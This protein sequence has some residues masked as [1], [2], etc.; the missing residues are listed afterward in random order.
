MTAPNSTN[1]VGKALKGKGKLTWTIAK[2][3]VRAKY[4]ACFGKPPADCYLLE[5]SNTSMR[6]E[7]ITVEQLK[8]DV[9]LGITKFSK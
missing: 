5:P 2:R 9:Q 3:E 7:W 6:S 8:R 1:L 4:I